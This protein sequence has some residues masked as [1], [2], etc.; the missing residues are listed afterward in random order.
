MKSKI[1]FL[2]FL[3]SV[4][5]YSQPIT[6]NTTTYTVPQLVQ[7]VLFGNGTAGS[8]C[9]GTISNI[10]WSTGSNFGSVNGIGYF[11]NTNPT[12]PMTSGVILSTGNVTAAPGPNTTT[13]SNGSD[14]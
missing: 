7:D 11:S 13:Q 5:S 12:F 10:T 9:V 14:A 6:V 1:L 2:L 8:S 4:M 3:I